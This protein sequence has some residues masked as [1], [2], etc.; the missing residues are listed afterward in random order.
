MNNFRAY[1]R[2]NERSNI[3]LNYW[4]NPMAIYHGKENLLKNQEEVE[5]RLGLKEMI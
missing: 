2:E 1:K 5:F 4:K 3:I